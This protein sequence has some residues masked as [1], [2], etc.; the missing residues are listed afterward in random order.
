MLN[1]TG[2]DEFQRRI[3]QLRKNAEQLDGE[4]QVPV[5]ELFPP[6]FMRQHSKVSDFDTFCRDSGLDASSKDGF[7]SISVQQ[8]DLATQQLTE[9]ANWGEMKKAGAA[10]WAKRRL[11]DG[12]QR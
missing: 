5:L 2:L 4:H 9:F 12:F 10:D 1:I 8:L 6:A 11:F 3:D 7:A